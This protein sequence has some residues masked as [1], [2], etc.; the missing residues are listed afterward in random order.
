MIVKVRLFATL[1]DY[2]PTYKYGTFL[3]VE[4]PDGAQVKD[5]V[6]QLN[7]PEALV[8]LSYVNGV[9]QDMDYRL[10]ENDEVGMFP[11]IGG[12]CLGY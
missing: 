5:L 2:V 7:L 8:K 9:Y 11:P 1:R 3:E 10:C 6:N 4:L 12:G